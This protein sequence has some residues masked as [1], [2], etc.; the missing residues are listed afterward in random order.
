MD[1]QTNVPANQPV[2]QNQTSGFVF[3]PAGKIFAQAKEIYKAKFHSLI[4]ISLCSVGA[5]A[6]SHLFSTN[7]PIY[8]KISSDPA[9]LTWIVLSVLI[10]FFAIFISLWAFGATIHNINS[11]ET[12]PT[13]DKSFSESYN[14]IIPLILTGLLAF[15]F[16]LGGLILLIIPG[17]IF[18][19]WYGQSAYVVMTENLSGKKALDRS[20]F[21]AT[22]NIYQIFK[23][24][25]YIG[26]LSFLIALATGLIFG[27]LGKALN[28]NFV[29][30]IGS[31]IFQLFWTPLASI[32]AF[33]LFQNLKQSKTSASSL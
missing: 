19:F 13:A 7:G 5:M 8:L 9:R 29:P 14:F 32:Y 3:P 24:G 10:S 18:A 12:T 28:L 25:F 16:I 2:A 21:Y 4:L 1:T 26:L 27:L 20:K 22:G 31:L 33:L 30:T 23:K 11:P 6:V 17:I 15:L